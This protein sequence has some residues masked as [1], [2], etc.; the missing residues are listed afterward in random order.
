MRWQ[1][2]AGSGTWESFVKLLK[3]RA[4][5][6]VQNVYFQKIVLYALLLIVQEKKGMMARRSISKRL[7]NE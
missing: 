2:E 3:Q 4:E 1:S 6:A 5:F 7:G